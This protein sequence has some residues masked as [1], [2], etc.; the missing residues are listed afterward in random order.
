MKTK[1][2]KI[3]KKSCI[4]A[5]DLGKTKHICRFVNSC[6]LESKLIPVYNNHGSFS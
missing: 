6:G 2:K 4:I 3:N 1:L 5:V